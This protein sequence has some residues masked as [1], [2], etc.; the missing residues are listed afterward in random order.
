KADGVVG[1]PPERRQ[2]RGSR[3]R[4]TLIQPLG[5]RETV[6]GIESAAV[7]QADE[8]NREASTAFVAE[9]GGERCTVGRQDGVDR[10]GQRREH[11]WLPAQYRKTLHAVSVACHDCRTVWCPRRR[12]EWCRL[13]ARR[14]PWSRGDRPKLPR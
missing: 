13:T 3:L 4:R 5:G 9:T 11:L 8:L 2:L 14:R 7:A 10:E 12:G 1:R 6:D